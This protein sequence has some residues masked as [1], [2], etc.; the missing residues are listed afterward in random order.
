[1]SLAGTATTMSDPNGHNADNGITG[2]SGGW[3]LHTYDLSPW[4]GQT[5]RLGLRY[6]TDSGVANEGFYADDLHPV[7]TWTTTTVLS[8][9]IAGTSYPVVGQPEGTYWY[10]ARGRDAEGDWGYLAAPQAVTVQS[11]TG[12][13]TLGG[14]RPFFL[15]A[16][17]PNP[18][19]GE[20]SIRFGLPAAG[21]H[22]LVVYD[23]SGRR[24]RSLS[25]GPLEA[26]PHAVRWDGRND[27]G[28]LVPSGVYFCRLTAAGAGELRER[29]V[30]RR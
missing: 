29:A 16:G 21:S 2:S 13:A 30:V 22:T 12:V 9:A 24:V 8:S 4:A 3:Q 17:A 18:F 1:V 20:T 19:R 25:S 7:Q 26:G 11:A 23:V 28:R 14:P 10:R 5:V 27:E 15:A 6:W